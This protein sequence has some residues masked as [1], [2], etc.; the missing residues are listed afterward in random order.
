MLLGFHIA[1]NIELVHNI[2]CSEKTKN[3]K[4]LAMKSPHVLNGYKIL[5][6]Y[7]VIRFFDY[8]VY[9]VISQMSHR[10]LQITC[11]KHQF[12]QS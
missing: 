11:S 7:V 1:K 6:D 3:Y 8:V 12:N 10:C 9:G 5:V 2:F 4:I